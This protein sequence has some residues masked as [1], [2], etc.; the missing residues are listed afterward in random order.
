MTFAVAAACVSASLLA[1]ADGGAA[2][3]SDAAV[4]AFRADCAAKAKAAEAAGTMTV[5][6]KD[7]WLF[8]HNELRHVGVGAFW[9][10]AAK[11]SRARRDPDPLPAIVDYKAQLDRLGIELILLPVPPK[12]IVY[13]DKLSAHVP[14]GAGGVPPRLDTA[15]QRFYAL[16]RDK[17][18]TVLDLTGDL[19]AARADKRSP[20]VYCRQDTH[21]SGQACVL[22]AK[23]IARC[24]KD[25]PWV[26]A[27]RRKPLATATAAVE[28][29]GDLWRAIK[30]PKPPRE[31]LPLRFVGARGDVRGS[32]VAIEAGSPVLL[33]AD[34]HGLVFHDPALHE[35]GAGLA[36]QLAFELGTAV[37]LI[38]VRGSGATPARISLYRKQKRTPGYLATKKLLI[39][40]FAARE[41][42]ESDG[43]RKV[44]VTRQ[45][46][47]PRGKGP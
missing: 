17:G 25:R 4:R 9:S 44:P 23:R 1:G 35:A 33:L 6:G 37:E 46:T 34:S 16:L 22:A 47:R 39:W 2:A 10:A 42:T 41:F 18:V 38:A 30:D 24:V 8:F 15:H 28:I 31:T 29:S 27:I 5:A 45:P 32:P 40:C 43:W 7:G 36:D 11:V 14:T 26:K 20:P 19:L 13:A 3:P 12:A 21:W